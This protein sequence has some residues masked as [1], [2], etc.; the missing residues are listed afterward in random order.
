[1]D[2]TI[3]DLTATSLSTSQQGFRITGKAGSQLGLSVSGAGDVNGDAI[4][5]IIIGA[6]EAAN[7]GVIGTAYIIFWK[8][9]LD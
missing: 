3:S 1:M 2:L 4:D 6:R 7:G 5:D 9:K 8:R